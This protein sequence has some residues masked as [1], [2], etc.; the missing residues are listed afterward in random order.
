VA[1]RFA[2]TETQ[3]KALLDRVTALETQLTTLTSAARS[4]GN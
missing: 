4:P 2:Q 1:D 3:D